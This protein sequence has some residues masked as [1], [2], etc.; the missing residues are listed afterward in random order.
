VNSL[1]QIIHKLL[2]AVHVGKNACKGIDGKRESENDADRYLKAG[3]ELAPEPAEG[4]AEGYCEKAY[5]KNGPHDAPLETGDMVFI[6]YLRKEDLAHD[7]LAPV[8]VQVK[9][10]VR[11]KQ[12]K[13]LRKHGYVMAALRAVQNVK[14]D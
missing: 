2:Q 13:L 5:E 12:R 4:M 6:L 10:G 3:P 1:R 8:A 11:A 14:L 7:L 9:S